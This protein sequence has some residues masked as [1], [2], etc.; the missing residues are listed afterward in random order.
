MRLI[1]DYFEVLQTRDRLFDRLDDAVTKPRLCIPRITR[2]FVSD[3]KPI[4]D[5]D[6]EDL[7]GDSLIEAVALGRL[8][9]L[10][11]FDSR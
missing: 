4:P 7:L 5:P 9:G 3:A 2:K 11:R 6:D 10:D 8:A 1:D